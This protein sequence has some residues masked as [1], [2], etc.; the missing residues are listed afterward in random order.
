V[1]GQ[2]GTGVLASAEVFD[3]AAGAWAPAA[4]MGT[5]RHGHAAVTLPDG[6][7]LVTG[8]SGVRPGQEDGALASAELFHPDTGTWTAA[9]PMGDARTGHRAVVLGDGRVLV[10]GGAVPTGNGREEAL[11]HCELY[12]PG[13]DQWTPTGTLSQARKGHQATVLPT[14]RVLVTGG[15][16]VVAAD[17]TV[18]P[19][20]LATAELFDPATRQWSAAAAMPGGRARHRH[21]LLRSELVL[22]LGGTGAPEATAGFRSVLA[23]DHTDGSW[24]T[25]DGLGTGRSGFGVVELA[26]DRVLVAGGVASAGAAAEDPE[27]GTP[28]RPSE[29]LIP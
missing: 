11:A 2:S 13:Q 27:A 18:D 22:V 7:I 16:P 17:G 15:D 21:L 1:G 9:T 5:A 10:I 14:G 4:A 3:P 25:V 23:Y 6:R 20:S 19:H 26:D 8:G 28:A 24:S 29:V 12:D